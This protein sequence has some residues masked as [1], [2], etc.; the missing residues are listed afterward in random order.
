MLKCTEHHYHDDLQPL[1]LDNDRLLEYY[2]VALSEGRN[3]VEPQ[4]ELL[5]NILSDVGTDFEC[6]KFTSNNWSENDWTKRLV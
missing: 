5:K 4:A 2:E 1:F 6:P 3:E